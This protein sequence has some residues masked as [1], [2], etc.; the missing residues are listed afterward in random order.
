MSA[1]GVQEG[2]RGREGGRE[3]ER[4]RERRRR[5]R[6]VCMLQRRESREASASLT[7]PARCFLTPRSSSLE[8]L[9][10]YKSASDDVIV[11]LFSLYSGTN[12]WDRTAKRGSSVYIIR[13]VPQ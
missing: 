12:E 8:Y 4:E 10:C 13:N 6:F 11:S 1:G 7:R 9:N 3:E 2:E 5:A